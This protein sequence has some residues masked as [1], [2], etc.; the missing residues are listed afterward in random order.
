VPDAPVPDS[1]VPD[2][3]VPDAPVPDSSVPGIVRARIVGGGIKR[4]ALTVLR[5]RFRFQRRV[6]FESQIHSFTRGGAWSQR[7]VRR[8]DAGGA[9]H[10]VPHGF[11]QRVAQQRSRVADC[12]GTALQ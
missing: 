6:R 4:V 12:Q 9:G 3:P 10:A 1:P 8:S 11:H 5:R 2:S 7:N